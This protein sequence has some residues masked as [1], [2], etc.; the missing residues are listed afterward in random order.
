MN[1]NDSE[2][3]APLPTQDLPDKD[4]TGSGQWSEFLRI[5]KF[6]F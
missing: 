4:N 6:S 3:R 2:D 1:M 5:R